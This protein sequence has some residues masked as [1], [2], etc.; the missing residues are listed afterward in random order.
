LADEARFYAR[1][2]GESLRQGELLSSLVE[3]RRV[4]SANSGSE[5]ID[6]VT[7]PYAV[8]ISQDCDLEQDF[9]ART[10]EA[11]LSKPSEKLLPSILFCEATTGDELKGRLADGQIWKQIT[12]NKNERY[13][14][15]RGIPK[16]WDSL[17]DGTPDLGIDF[18][19]YFTIPTSEVYSQIKTLAKRR[20]QLRSPYLEHFSL[21]FAY[22]LCRVGLPEEHLVR[23]TPS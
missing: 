16:D 3:V 17:G 13:Q 19:R 1:S 5:Q 2:T 18:K 21:R 6:L 9:F 12:Q 23:K 22:Y 15:L 7:H 14:Y 4:S 8:V 10:G 20:A 11:K